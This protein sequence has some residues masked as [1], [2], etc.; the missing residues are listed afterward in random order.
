[1]GHKVVEEMVPDVW[2]LKIKYMIENHKHIY[3]HTI[4][5]KVASYWSKTAWMGMII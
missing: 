3:F 1:M 4:E 5:K 2:I